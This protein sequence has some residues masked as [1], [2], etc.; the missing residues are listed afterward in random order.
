MEGL[1]ITRT[2]AW[3]ATG[4][5]SLLVALSCS[6]KLKDVGAIDAGGKSASGGSAGSTSD[7]GGTTESGGSAGSTSDSGGTTESGGS[8]RSSSDVCLTSGG[9][10][11]AGINGQ[12]HDRGGS[13]GSGGGDATAIAGSDRTCFSELNANTGD[14]APSVGPQNAVFV[15]AHIAAGSDVKNYA[16][17][18][19]FGDIGVWE[20][21]ANFPTSDLAA[22]TTISLPTEISRALPNLGQFYITRQ[23]CAGTPAAG[24]KLSVEVWWKLGGAIGG[25]PTEGLALGTVSKNEPV[26]FDD[27]V[28]AF[29]TGEPEAKRVMNT[30]NKLVIEHV[31]ADDDPTDAGKVTLGLWLLPDFDFPSKFYIGKVKWD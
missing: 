4:G 13:G 10:L 19:V 30:L 11:V 6:G 12:Q 17:Q 18:I 22:D 14:T 9:C 31:F 15:D 16:D 8:A 29:V 20:A 27:T 26:W 23:S 25:F 2:L 21:Y 3:S 24:H 7:S 1:M 5:V 28:H